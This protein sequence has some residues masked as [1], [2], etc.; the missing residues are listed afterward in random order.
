MPPINCRALLAG[1]SVDSSLTL[2]RICNFCGK[3]RRF[4]SRFRAERICKSDAYADCHSAAAGKSFDCG[5]GR[6]ARD[7]N[8]GDAHS[9]RI[10]CQRARDSTLDVVDRVTAAVKR[11][12]VARRSSRI[13]ER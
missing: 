9:Q 6:A 8:P 7:R 12:M 2:D 1:D 4:A 10:G 13:L 11:A 3:H 5:S